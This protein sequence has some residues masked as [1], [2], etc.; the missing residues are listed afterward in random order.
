GTILIVIFWAMPTFMTAPTGLFF[1]LCAASAFL[2]GI[3]SRRAWWMAAAAC[4]LLLGF[5]A[6][7]G[8]YFLVPSCLV[9]GAALAWLEKSSLR[10]YL[11]HV[12]LAIAI[13]FMVPRAITAF[14][15][16]DSK[17]FQG[18]FSY[19][20]Y[21]MAVGGENWRQILVDHP[22][23]TELKDRSDQYDFIYGKAWLAIK[24]SPSTIIESYISQ[25]GSMPKFISNSIVW[26]YLLVTDNR[27]HISEEA[28]QYAFLGFFL[29][30]LFGII[31]YLAK[32]QSRWRRL[33]L[34]VLLAGFVFSL[35]F[36]TITTEGEVVSL[37]IYAVVFPLLAGLAGL[38]LAIYRRSAEACESASETRPGRLMNLMP[39]FLAAVVLVA[40]FA[41]PKT[42]GPSIFGSDLLLAAQKR[43][44]KS[45]GK[46]LIVLG[47]HVPFI[48]VVVDRPGKV[49]RPDVE[50]SE[51]AEHP[52]LQK[53]PDAFGDLA[54]GDQVM[55]A[56][57]LRRKRRYF[58]FTRE[59]CMPDRRWLFEAEV[60][61][62]LPEGPY[63]VLK[64][65][66]PLG[67]TPEQT[68]SGELPYGCL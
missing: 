13:G 51:A 59:L 23:F 42:L 7:S 67:L 36:L 31:R 12:V 58:L 66:R 11:L 22:E 61:R 40:G 37:R 16:G 24:D 30:L 62:K 49:L 63:Y 1:G 41:V 57:E 29:I 8:P 32:E 56:I 26:E 21:Q 65:I 53:F 35:P 5:A 50:R 60:E 20:L 3:E 4:L 46:H 19:V 45:K 64:S 33:G 25:L 28:L 47:P 10:I 54:P 15:N 39:L 18:N 38:P 9:L 48:R 17:S 34:L 68:A 55:N 43:G 2:A 14:Y 6:R 52:H 44:K 27:D